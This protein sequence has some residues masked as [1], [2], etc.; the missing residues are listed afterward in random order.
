MARRNIPAGVRRNFA[1]FISW[2][3][4]VDAKSAPKARVM[5]ARTGPHVKFARQDLLEAGMAGKNKTVSLRTWNA[6]VMRSRRMVNAVS[7]AQASGGRPRLVSRVHPGML[8]AKTAKV[9]ENVCQTTCFVRAIKLAGLAVAAIPYC[10]IHN[11]PDRFQLCT[12]DSRIIASK[13]RRQISPC[14]SLWNQS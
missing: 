4:K 1:R 12:T 13:D 6:K 8:E 5:L 2:R 11:W 9:K 14:I 3:L 7:A 10:D